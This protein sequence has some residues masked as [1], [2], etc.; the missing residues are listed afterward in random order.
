MTR[1]HPRIAE[2]LDHLDRHHIALRAAVDAVPSA[3]RGQ[4]P[5][6]DRWSVSE[7]LE[8]LGLVERRF[9]QFF[10]A[11]VAEARARGL[12]ADPETTPVVPAF[13]V[14]AAVDRRRTITALESVVPR[15]DLDA[16]R[17]WTALDDAHRGLRAEMVAADGCAL[18]ELT[19]SHPAF[20]ALDFYQ[21]LVF[22]GAHESRHADQIREIG[23]ALSAPPPVETVQPNA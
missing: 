3:L 21:W 2:L 4:R 1:V 20:G 15:G 16:E 7:V 23:R 8:H 14:A 9:T 13:D 18:G 19:F 17:A 6:P 11:R 12:G 22:L 5:A 10:A